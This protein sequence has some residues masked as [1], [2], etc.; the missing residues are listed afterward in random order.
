MGPS[1]PGRTDPGFGP[2]GP[3]T[4]GPQDEELTSKLA[5]TIKDK[6]KGLVGFQLLELKLEV[7]AER[8]PRLL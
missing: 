3:R 2:F 5:I 7:G 8:A 6:F 1:G 4:D